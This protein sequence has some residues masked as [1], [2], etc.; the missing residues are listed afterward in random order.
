MNVNVEI[1]T[2]EEFEKN[3]FEKKERVSLLFEKMIHETEDIQPF[4]NTNAGK[5]INEALLVLLH[6]KQK[7][8]MNINE[9]FINNL[10]SAEGIYTVAY[11]KAKKGVEG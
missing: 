2:I 7:Y 5:L 11:E 9:E 4:F 8:L 3:I 10:K 6:K 1:E